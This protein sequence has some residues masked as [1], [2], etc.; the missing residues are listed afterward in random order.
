MRITPSFRNAVIAATAELS[1]ASAQRSAYTQASAIRQEIATDLARQA[2]TL[3]V[4][5]VSGV[6]FFGFYWA[7]SYVSLYRVQ[8]AT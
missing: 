5:T 8:K 1:A 6:S 4:F 2:K 3:A 7:Y